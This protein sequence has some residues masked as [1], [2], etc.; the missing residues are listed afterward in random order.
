MHTLLWII[1]GMLAIIFLTAG[2]MKINGVKGNI[3]Q[4]AHLD[5]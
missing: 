5:Q 2:G 3:V 1:Q 4:P